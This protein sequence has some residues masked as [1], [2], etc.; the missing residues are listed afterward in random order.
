MADVLISMD[1]LEKVSKQL[2]AIVE[3][4]EKAATRADALHQAI[5]RPYGRT[6]LRDATDDFE[7]RWDLERE[8][9]KDGLSEIREHVDAVIDGVGEWDSQTALSL[10][11][12]PVDQPAADQAGGS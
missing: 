11:G 2:A 4:F 1:R 5:G 8:Q 3:E 10:D 12:E 9:L 6:E 7:D